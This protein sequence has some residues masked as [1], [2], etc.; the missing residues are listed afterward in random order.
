MEKQLTGVFSQSRTAV[1]AA[2]EEQLFL[3]TKATTLDLGAGN[4]LVEVFSG[5]CSGLSN[6][7]L[8][9][10]QFVRAFSNFKKSGAPIRFLFF[11]KGAW[12]DV[13]HQ[14]F[15]ELK[16]GFLAG[17]TTLKVNCDGKEYLLDFLRMLRIGMDTRRQNSIAWID[18]HGRCYFPANAVD[19]SG[20]Q[21][22][23]SEK[24]DLGLRLGNSLLLPSLSSRP[25][26]RTNANF[27]CAK[28]F[29]G[30]DTE[31]SSP[32]WPDTRT[33]RDDGKSY[34]VVERLF[35]SG[36]KK[37]IRDVVVTSIHRC[38]PSTP[39]GKSRLLSVRLHKSATL[40]ARG[41]ANVKFGWYGTSATDIT[42]IMSYGFR[43]PNSGRLG[44]SAHGVGIHLSPLYSPFSSATLSETDEDDEK[45]V[46][47]CRVIMGNPE[48]VP[49]GSTQ[50]QPS[51]NSFDT[52][53]DSFVNPN[54]YVV[55]STHMNTHIVPE[56]I[57]SFKSS[58]LRHGPG[59]LLGMH[60]LSAVADLSFPTILAE[61]GSFL[62]FSKTQAL[63]ILYNRYKVGR[64]SKETFMKHI[65]L[66]MGDNLLIAFV[67]R[68]R[69]KRK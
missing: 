67:R 7:F 33:L 31:V 20:N 16:E 29:I 54:W 38:S 24:I 53:V 66:I 46:F 58:E 3:R 56:Y 6:G 17:K 1:A 51:N 35:L 27:D 37:Y 21:E 41:R 11:S 15:E 13:D 48:E 50:D 23:I 62:P 34:K 19:E 45:H 63:E 25:P 44:S 4:S 47:L 65:R 59:K 5:E 18:V 52:A 40:K 9:P 69:S 49:A 61:M 64:I 12:L 36:I 57:V 8:L 28:E 32:R 22:N 39:S 30:E 14:A 26:G 2:T 43:Q 55:W 42:T 60:K 68:S 10:E